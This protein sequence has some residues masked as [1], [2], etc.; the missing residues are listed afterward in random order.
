[1]VACGKKREEDIAYPLAD[2]LSGDYIRVEK[3]WN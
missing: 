1:M 3:L 2:K